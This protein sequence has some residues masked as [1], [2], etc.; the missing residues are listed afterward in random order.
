MIGMSYRN[1][2]ERLQGKLPDWRISQLIEAS[3]LNKGKLKIELNNEIYNI[4]I[5]KEN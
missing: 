5:H 4:D 2:Q 1:Y 3:K